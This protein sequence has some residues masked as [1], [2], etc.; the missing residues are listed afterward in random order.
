LAP[1]IKAK[2]SKAP[3]P[4]STAAHTPTGV[5]LDPSER[6]GGNGEAIGMRHS[7]FLRKEGFGEPDM[8]PRQGLR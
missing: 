7:R 8:A 4:T 2:A 1:P 6:V 3:G 5:V